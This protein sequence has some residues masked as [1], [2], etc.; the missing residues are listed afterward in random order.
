MP[1]YSFVIEAVISMHIDVDAGSLQ[2]AIEEAKSRGPQ[3]LCWQCARGDP[4]E[5]STSGELDTDPSMSK[6]VDCCVDDK[7]IT[8]K[9]KKLWDAK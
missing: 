1:K 6:L 9:T 3:S 2:A 8:G 7:P 4:D 5:W